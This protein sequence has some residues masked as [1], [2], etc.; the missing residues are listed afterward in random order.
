MHSPHSLIVILIQLNIATLVLAIMKKIAMTVSTL[1]MLLL[2]PLV[3]GAN[4]YWE[5]QNDGASCQEKDTV[6]KMS[7]RL[8]GCC[9]AMDGVCCA[10]GDHCCPS[11]YKCDLSVKQCLKYEEQT[12]VAK[13]MLYV[14]P[15]E[16]EF[17]DEVM[18]G[19]ELTVPRIP[20]VDAKPLSGD[21]DVGNTVPCPG[22]AGVCPVNTT[23]CMFLNGVYGCCPTPYGNCCFDYLSCC[24]SGNVCHRIKKTCIKAAD[25]SFAY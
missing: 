3:F 8:S 1:L 11:G 7:S 18:K 25:L 20:F 14:A 15:A 10:D 5:F 4:A 24:P 2:L 17:G 22:N 9:P 21:H 6:C 19:P 16:A 12:V 23:C 13:E